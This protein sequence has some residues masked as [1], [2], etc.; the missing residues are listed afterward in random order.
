MAS[1]RNAA[2]I[3]VALEVVMNLFAPVAMDLVDLE[4]LCDSMGRYQ[5]IEPWG[6]VVESH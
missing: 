2:R 3:G 1:P 4:T 5:D 6:S